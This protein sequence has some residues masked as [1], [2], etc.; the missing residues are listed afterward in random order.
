VMGTG[1]WVMYWS[2]M[3]CANPPQGA[4]TVITGSEGEGGQRAAGLSFM[5]GAG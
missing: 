3:S 4:Q 1:G 5:V 2:V